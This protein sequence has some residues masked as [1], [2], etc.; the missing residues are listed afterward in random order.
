[1]CIHFMWGIPSSSAACTSPVNTKQPHD[2][3]YWPKNFVGPE[4]CVY[5]RDTCVSDSYVC[6]HVR[7]KSSASSQNL[8]AL[9]FFVFALAFRLSL[10]L[11]RLVF[12]FISIS[13]RQF[14]AFWHSCRDQKATEIKKKIGERNSTH[15]W[16]I[17]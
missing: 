16:K 7:K 8:S 10:S 11:F 3:V 12:I 15:C 14:A 5:F 2:F 9:F 4:D 6:I 1:M 13:L 17:I